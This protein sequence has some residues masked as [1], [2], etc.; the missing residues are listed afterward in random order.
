MKDSTLEARAK[1]RREDA[2]ELVKLRLRVRALEE[3]VARLRELVALYE[4][5]DTRRRTGL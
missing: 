4:D 2:G 3:E 1:K 5:K